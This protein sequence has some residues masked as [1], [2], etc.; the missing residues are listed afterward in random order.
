MHSMVKE[1]CDSSMLFFHIEKNV[2]SIGDDLR[3]HY[4]MGYKDFPKTF[5]LFKVLIKK[6]QFDL[7]GLGFM[8]HHWDIYVE[9]SKVIRKTLPNCKIIA[10]GV[11]AWHISQSDTLE[12]C[13]YICAAEGPITIVNFEFG[14]FLIKSS[15]TPVDK[16][17]S[18]IRFEDITSIF[19][20]ISCTIF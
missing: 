14:Y 10:G 7:I 18:P 1:K 15:I 6:N 5:D 3:F 9:L 19:T 4:S 8:S 20:R 13:D 17:V 12:H 11:H 16:T 2:D